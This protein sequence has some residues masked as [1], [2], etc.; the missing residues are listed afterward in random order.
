[1]KIKLLTFFTILATAFFSS[2]FTVQEGTQALLVQ[3]GE[4]ISKEPIKPGI[5]F[6][7]PLVQNVLRIEKRILNLTSDSR[8][9]IA[10]DQKRLIVNYYAKYA[11]KEPIKFY[12]SARTETNLESRLKPIVESYM[13]EQIGLVPLIDL[14]T[15]RRSSVMRQIKEGATKEAAKFGVEI[16]DVRIKRTDLPEENSEAIFRRMETERE[17]EAKEI[18]AEGAE[19]ARKIKAAAEKEKVLILSEA[20]KKGQIAKGEGEANAAAIFNSAFSQDEDFFNF[21]RHMQAYKKSF[22]NGTTR[23]I[24]DINDEKSFLKFFREE[25]EK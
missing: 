19:E 13:R 11:I 10:A 24:L 25:F 8:E 21:Y 3:L 16:I 14:L 7:I 22:S 6:K 12:L 4:I 23:V 15:E 1:M 20:Y 18:R 9:V 5:H 2:V 17:K